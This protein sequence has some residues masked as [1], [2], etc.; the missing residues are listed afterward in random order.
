MRYLCITALLS[1]FFNLALGQNEKIIFLK[2]PSFEGIPK[3]STLPEGWSDCGFSGESP[4]DLHPND[5]FGVTAKAFHGNTYIG[6]V[7]RD[8]NTWES[9]G[10]ELH[11]A[12]KVGKEYAF[13]IMLSRSETYMSFSRKPSN[14]NMQINYNTPT[15]LRIW[16]SQDGCTRDELLAISKPITHEDWQ[17]YQFMLSPQEGEYSH[18]ILEAYYSGQYP[19]IGNLLIDDA[20]NIIIASSAKKLFTNYKDE[21]D[22]YE[23]PEGKERFYAK[24]ETSRLSTSIVPPVA[25][26]AEEKEK[27][28]EIEEEEEDD[29]LETFEDLKWVLKENGQKISFVKGKLEKGFYKYYDRTFYQNVYVHNIISALK[30]MPDY[31]LSIAVFGKTSSDVKKKTKQLKKAFEELGLYSNRYI[32]VEWPDR[33]L[34]K[35]WIWPA[36]INDLLIRVEE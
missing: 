8:N 3:H 10:Q 19:L 4:A 31:R 17:R 24:K 6:L 29:V 25:P 27:N 21:F 18:L 32:F 2:N 34:A 1:I 36:N 9:I 7:V 14:A 30:E 11:Q 26:P 33:I 5:N 13:Q 22:N 15:I 23:L 28:K 16:A 20:S 35:D 12:L